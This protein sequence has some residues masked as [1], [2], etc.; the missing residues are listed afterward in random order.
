MSIRFQYNKTELQNL[1]RQL[2]VRLRALPT[3]KN[4]EAALRIEVKKAKD[5]ILKMEETFRLRLDASSGSAGLWNEFLPGLI[6]VGEVKYYMIK[7]AGVGIPMFSE[8]IFNE[9]D[10]SIFELPKWF[11]EGFSILKNLA[12]ILLEKDFYVVKMNLLDKARRKTTQKVNL[13][14]KVQIPDYENAI[15]KIKR[16]LE[17]EENLSKSAQKLIKKRQE[18][19]AEEMR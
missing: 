7:I 11:P 19:Q 3:L 16:F 8:V 1:N 13:Y 4:K 12:V 2:N 9:Q 17:D 15:R 6:A 10:Y 14:E 5:H 18:T